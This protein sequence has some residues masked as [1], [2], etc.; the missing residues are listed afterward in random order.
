M[1]SSDA[2]QYNLNEQLIQWALLRMLS[3]TN[4]PYFIAGDFNI[5][6]AASEVIQQSLGSGKVVDTFQE[7][8][9]DKENLH[10]TFCRT[11]V[12][13]GMRGPQKTR[14]DTILANQLAAALVHKVSF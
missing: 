4:T 13:E 5:D 7:W 12:Y 3:F 8:E 6:P 9:T 10:P 14:I 11:G 2:H 1:A